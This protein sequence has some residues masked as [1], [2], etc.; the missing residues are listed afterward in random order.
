MGRMGFERSWRGIGG[1]AV[2]WR[3]RGLHGV[4]TAS[5]PVDVVLEMWIVLAESDS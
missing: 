3:L 5:G 1:R 4:R 2:I